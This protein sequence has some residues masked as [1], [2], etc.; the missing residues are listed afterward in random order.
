MASLTKI[1]LLLFSFTLFSYD[2][3][4]YRETGIVGGSE[5]SWIRVFN[6]GLLQGT[7]APLDPPTKYVQ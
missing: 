2:V 5:A 4:R 6:C 7:L 1:R 3:S